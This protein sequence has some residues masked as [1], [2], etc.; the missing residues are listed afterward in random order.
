[1]IE[2]HQ[3]NVLESVSVSEAQTFHELVVALGDENEAAMRWRQTRID[4][5]VAATGSATWL[6]LPSGE[7]RMNREQHDSRVIV[8]SGI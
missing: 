4:A 8:K 6:A 3:S 5:G 7:R 2:L 1:M